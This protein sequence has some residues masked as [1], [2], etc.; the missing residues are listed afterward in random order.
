[1]VTTNKGE[2]SSLVELDEFVKFVLVKS[3]DRFV[4]DDLS[5]QKGWSRLA[6]RE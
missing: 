3:V 6:L 5:A 4:V 1:M 2:T